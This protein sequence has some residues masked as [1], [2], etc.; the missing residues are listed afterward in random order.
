MV[1]PS[2]SNREMP[3]PTDRRPPGDQVPDAVVADAKAAFRYRSNREVAVLVFD[4]LVDG[5][6]E[7]NEHLLRFEHPSQRVELII[8]VTDGECAL[9]GHVDPAPLRVELEM[10]GSEVALVEDAASGDFSFDRVPHGLKRMIL[11][12]LPGS[13]PVQTDWFRT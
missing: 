3:A 8:S 5:R 13:E 2:S 9:R 6:A 7:A 4:S 11:V 10:K 1:D 12:G